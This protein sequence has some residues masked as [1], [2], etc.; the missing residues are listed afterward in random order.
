MKK[1][2]NEDAIMT[3]AIVGHIAFIIVGI[4]GCILILSI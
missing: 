2:F 1:L 3:G 4:V